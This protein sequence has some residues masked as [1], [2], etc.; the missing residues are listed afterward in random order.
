MPR[1][2]G[3]C[4]VFGHFNIIIILSVSQSTAEHRPF[5][6]CAISPVKYTDYQIM[7]KWYFLNNIF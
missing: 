2:L 7:K 1:K 5:P 4:S 3:Y 6:M